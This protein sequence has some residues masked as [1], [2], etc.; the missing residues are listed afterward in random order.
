MT[1][2]EAIKII[3][4]SN[5]RNKLFPIEAEA[6]QH[7]LQIAEKSEGIL[8][9]ICWTASFAPVPKGTVNSLEVKNAD[10]NIICQMCRANEEIKRLQ[11][12]AERAGDVEGI[13]SIIIDEE[14]V[15]T[16]CEDSGQI[17]WRVGESRNLAQSL[18]K[19]LKG[20]EKW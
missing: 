15:P 12:I 16:V 4:N 1:T 18:S 17:E 3:K 20:E 8:C 9:D 6:L 19:W 10:Y 2:Q 14:L 13:R 5:Y 7:L 11:L